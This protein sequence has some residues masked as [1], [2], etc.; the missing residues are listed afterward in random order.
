MGEDVSK[1]IVSENELHKEIGYK[2]KHKTKQWV[3]KTNKG[4]LCL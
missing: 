1:P 2:G 4:S 3:N